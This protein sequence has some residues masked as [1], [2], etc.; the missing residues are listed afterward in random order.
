[1]QPPLGSTVTSSQTEAFV[2]LMTPWCCAPPESRTR[3]ASAQHAPDSPWSASP[4][5]PAR[6]F[7]QRTSDG[8]HHLPLQHTIASLTTGSSQRSRPNMPVNQ[9]PS[10]LHPPTT[11]TST[12]HCVDQH[13][14][15]A[16]SPMTCPTS[17]PGDP[18][19]SACSRHQGCRWGLCY[20]ARYHAPFVVPLP[21]IVPRHSSGIPRQASA[22]CSTWAP[23]RHPTMRASTPAPIGPTIIWTTDSQ[24]L[25]PSETYRPNCVS[26]EGRHRC[27]GTCHLTGMGMGIVLRQGIASVCVLSMAGLALVVGH[28]CDAVRV[29]CL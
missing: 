19:L 12:E 1:M 24:Q 26:L 15:V 5:N 28:V 17:L 20:V 6:Q 29:L 23:C 7:L 21:P 4:V 13:A 14:P 11:Q 25:N 9:A 16:P 8:T 18:C 27:G 2:P 3:H 10:H 22:H